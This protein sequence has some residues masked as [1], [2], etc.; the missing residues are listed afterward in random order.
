M[1][2][3]VQK[4]RS[5]EISEDSSS[6]PPGML[7][8]QVSKLG[9]SEYP[10]NAVSRK[11]FV[12]NYPKFLW[13]VTERPSKSM[14]SSALGLGHRA[15]S[16]GVDIFFEDLSLAVPVGNKAVNVV[17]RVTGRIRA[18]TMTALMGGSGAGKCI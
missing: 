11:D 6:R 15:E 1:G 2:R 9:F 7:F 8:N 10:R 5:M 18:K 4:F 16:A 17:D 12:E 13:A 14:A 3:C